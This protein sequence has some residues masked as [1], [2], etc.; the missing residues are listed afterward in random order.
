M[1]IKNKIRIIAHVEKIVTTLQ[2]K[3]SHQPT[4]SDEL[5]KLQAS[6]KKLTGFLTKLDEL[7]PNYSTNEINSYV[8]VI[9]LHVDILKSTL[10]KKDYE[11]LYRGVK[12][13]KM[14]LKFHPT[15]YSF[16][17]FIIDWFIEWIYFV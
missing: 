8:D 13:L 7:K 12:A 14:S 10:D 16:F 17:S 3:Y 11:K 4:T 2:E 15:K 1:S 6:L 5:K 9:N